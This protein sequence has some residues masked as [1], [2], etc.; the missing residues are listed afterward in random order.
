MRR[1]TGGLEE[2]VLGHPLVDDY[3]R[4]VAARGRTNTW[5]AVAYDLKGSSRS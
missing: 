4:F 3:L 1:D 5:L 2:I